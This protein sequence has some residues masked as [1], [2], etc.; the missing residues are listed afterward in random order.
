MNLPDAVQHIGPR[1]YDVL[2]AADPHARALEECD[3]HAAEATRLHPAWREVEDTLDEGRGD[4]IRELADDL[5][6]REALT[7]DPIP[8]W[9]IREMLGALGWTQARLAEAVGVSARTVRS[10]LDTG[11]HGRPCTGSSAVAVRSL[12]D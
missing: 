1:L 4:E 12:V 5:D 6:W 2:E 9:A 3:R 7:V 10:W 8:A 11:P